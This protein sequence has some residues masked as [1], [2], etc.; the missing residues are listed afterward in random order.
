MI[1]VINTSFCLEKF[2]GNASK[3]MNDRSL[4]VSMLHITAIKVIAWANY[5]KVDEHFYLVF[6]DNLP[7]LNC[8]FLNIINSKSGYM[9]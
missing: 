3:S 5:V 8:N 4:I 9:R 6:G 7:C 1:R 2:A